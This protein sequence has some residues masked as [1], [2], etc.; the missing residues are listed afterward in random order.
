MC[1]GCKYYNEDESWFDPCFTCKNYF[2]YQAEIHDSNWEKIKIEQ[3]PK[4]YLY[5]Y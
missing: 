5:E 2:L 4:G 3:E 1:E